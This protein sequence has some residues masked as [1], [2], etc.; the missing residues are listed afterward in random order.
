M[1]STGRSLALLNDAYETVTRAGG[2]V[3]VVLNE[4]LQASVLSR[5][6]L[7]VPMAT[8]VNYP[9]LLRSP[10]W[11]RS[12]RVG[13]VRELGLEPVRVGGE[14]TTRRHCSRLQGE[15]T[16]ARPPRRLLASTDIPH[17]DILRRIVVRVP[18]RFAFH[19][20]EVVSSRTILVCR[21]SALGAPF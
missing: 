2:L 18:F 19:T 13:L 1:V 11:V 16:V 7:R 21:E 10:G 3:S 14:S 4:F 15:L 17:P 5:V 8:V 9:T 12:L 20:S 6:A